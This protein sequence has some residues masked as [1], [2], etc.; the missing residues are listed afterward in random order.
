[1]WGTR[2]RSS[3]SGFSGERRLVWLQHIL[4]F[5]LVVVAPV[6]DHYEFKKLKASEDPL[7]KVRFYRKWLVLQWIFAAIALVAAGRGLWHPPTTAE[8]PWLHTDRAHSF[9]LGLVI[10]IVV[11]MAIPLF[12]LGKPKVRETIRKA[13]AKVGFFVPSESFEFPWFGALCVT[14]GICEEWVCRGFVLYYLAVA[15]WHLSLG[16]AVIL[17]AAIFGLNHLYQGLSGMATAGVLGA[18]FALLY[19][20]TG[21]LLLPMVLHALIDLRALALI[22]GAREREAEQQ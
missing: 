3:R 6:C 5:T 4:I 11:V 17:S 13:F 15:P 14:A 9:A 8:W 7:R 12:S 10:G 20:A 21:S 22:I 19:L 18:I 2:V 1:M 16:T